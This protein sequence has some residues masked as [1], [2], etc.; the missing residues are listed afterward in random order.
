LAA[1]FGF[2]LVNLL[3]G[4]PTIFRLTVNCA[5]LLARALGYGAARA[6]DETNKDDTVSVH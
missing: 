5:H 6:K 2:T 1:I 3:T 4:E